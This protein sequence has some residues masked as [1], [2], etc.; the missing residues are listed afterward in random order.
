MNT[1]LDSS[2]SSTSTSRQ[3]SRETTP[4]PIQ[5]QQLNPYRIPRFWR[6]YILGGLTGPGLYG[7]YKLGSFVRNY[8]RNKFRPQPTPTV[9]IPVITTTPSPSINDEP[10]TSNSNKK[11]VYKR[12][13]NHHP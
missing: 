9:S 4:L 1:P 10:K 11:K 13:I 8:L 6:G 3:S 12:N 2:Y 5:H 7:L